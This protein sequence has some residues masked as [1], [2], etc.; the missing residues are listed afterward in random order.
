M[1]FIHV[2]SYSREKYFTNLNIPHPHRYSRTQMHIDTYTYP[3]THMRKSARQ[4]KLIHC[5]SNLV[6]L[7]GEVEELQSKRYVFISYVCEVFEFK[8]RE[9]NSPLVSI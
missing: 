5:F 8:I 7:M 6:C 3:Y 2:H 9:T 4:W 1:T